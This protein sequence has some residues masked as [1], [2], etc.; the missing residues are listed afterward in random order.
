VRVTE[1]GPVVRVEPLMGLVVIKELA[2]AL[3][4]PRYAKTIRK[5]EISFIF[6][7]NS[8]LSSLDSHLSSHFFRL[9]IYPREGAIR[10][11]SEQ[12]C[13]HI[14]MHATPV[15]MSLRRSNPFLMI[16]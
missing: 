1:L 8:S 11:R 3:A 13:L 10:L 14:N 5:A 2:V 4:M 9:G 12:G 7:A 16:R 6:I 15:P